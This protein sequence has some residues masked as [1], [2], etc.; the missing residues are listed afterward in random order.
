MLDLIFSGRNVFI[1]YIVLAGR[2]LDPLIPCHSARLFEN[3]MW[4]RHLL[5]FLTLIFFVVI[6]DT[7][8]DDYLP[9]GSILAVAGVIYAWFL[10]SSKMTANWW[11]FLVLLLAGLYLIDLYESRQK[12]EDPTTAYVLDIVKK[13]SLGLG[14][15]LTFFGFLIYV[16]EKKLEY[17]SEFD[18]GTLLLGTPTCKGTPNK[19]PYLTSLKAAFL[20]RPWI[21]SPAPT[22]MK[23]GASELQTA[24]V[25]L[26]ANDEFRAVSSLS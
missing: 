16:G 1:L 25:N 12:D 3:S 9:L 10:L 2:F 21:V 11:V 19:T 18:W 26:L 7:E 6:A 23:G 14:A 24:T 8:I 15:I 13:V 4:L 17:K 5:G 20:S 22:I